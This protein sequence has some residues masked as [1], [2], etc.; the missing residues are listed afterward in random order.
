[1]AM[2]ARHVWMIVGGLGVAVLVAGGFWLFAFRDRA[3]P[4]NEEEL[5]LTVVTGSGAPGEPGVYAYTTTGRETTDALAGSEHVYPARTHLTIQPGGCGNLVRWQPLEERY[6]EWEICS[7]GTLTGFVSFH[8]WFRVANTDVWDCPEPAP[9]QGEPGQTWTTECTRVSSQEAGEGSRTASYEAVGF[10]T[11]VVGD[12]EVETLH[13]RVSALERGGTE[14]YRNSEMWFLPGTDLLVRWIEDASV[15][16]QSRIGPV[17]Y[18]EQ[19]EVI[20][21]SLRPGD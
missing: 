17:A 11:L 8:E 2:R 10:E 6:E 5:S 14:G 9:L 1:M 4:I 15:V 18:S 16:T 20:L 19:F 13:V 7:D 12:E 21:E 3:R